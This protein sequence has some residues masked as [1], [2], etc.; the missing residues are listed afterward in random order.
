MPSKEEQAAQPQ[1][2]RT[3]GRVDL[4]LLFV[5]A[6]FNIHVTPNIAANGGVTVWLFL[7]AVPLFFLPEA[8]AVIE[9]S[10][11][12]PEEGGI[13]L[14]TK[15]TFG[16]FHGFLS[17]WC[18]WTNNMLYLPSLLLYFV[19]LAAYSLGPG[20]ESLAE[21]KSFA[22]LVS[23]GLMGVLLVLNVVGLGIGKWVSNIGALGSG[24]GAAT[25]IVLGIIVSA[26]YGTSISASDFSIPKDFHLVL[27]SFGVIVFALSGLELASVM[28]DEIRDPRRTLALAVGLG[29]ILCS[30]LY[31]ATDL[32][33]LISV[34]P[35]RISV[36]QGVIQAASY[37]AGKLGLGWTIPA[38]AVV[39]SLSIAGTASAWLAGSA[40]IPFVAGLDS[41][42]PAW[43]GKLHPRYRT[44]Y[45]ALTLMALVALFLVAMNF[46]HSGVQEAFQKLL[47]LAVVL[48]LVPFLYMFAALLKIA[49]EE[50]AGKG[51]Y[52]KGI[53]VVAGM[54]GLLATTI[55]L[56]LI[57]FPA[58]RISSLWAYES[59]MLGG[60]T[61][62][63][64]TGAFFFFMYGRRKASN[65]LQ[66]PAILD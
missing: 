56:V 22:L 7:V 26:R 34:G 10:H 24:I 4:V 33:L 54:A 45:P 51:R 58:Q 28:G 42:L 8:I 50:S 15:K 48:Q 30:V 63:V 36:L 1:L 14:W 59:W 25:L 6:V 2:K 3:L 65:S 19:G 23:L 32:I 57:F 55:G 44:P 29:A 64:G 27:N 40:R 62:F 38:F 53:L 46:I 47:S 9:L 61:I 13:Y 43:L 17:G 18:Y 5:V 39:L 49:F 21:D 20:H 31:I 16:E 11:R 66:S 60:T 52:S 35:K 37:M 41:Y 12:Y